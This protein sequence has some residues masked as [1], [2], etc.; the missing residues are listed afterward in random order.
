MSGGAADLAVAGLGTGAIA[1]LSGLGLIATYRLTGVL[2]V[3][4]GAIGMLGAY[5]VRDLVRDAHL[6]EYAAGFIVVCCFAPLLGLALE[7][8]VFGPL[9]AARADAGRLL[10]AG[11][12]VAVLLV[13]IATAV[14]GGA[15][16]TDAPSLLPGGTLV[17]GGVSVAAAL[18]IEL[19]LVLLVALGLAWFSRGGPTIRAVIDDRQLAE[20]AGLPARRL[21]RIGW[22]VGTMLATLTGVL[23]APQLRF[24]PSTLT[25]VL[26]ETLGVAIAAGLRSAPLAIVFAFGTAIAQAEL[27]G[28]HLTG[29]AGSV[30]EAVRS[31]LFVV[32]LLLAT[33]FTPAFSELPTSQPPASRSRYLSAYILVLVFAVFAWNLRT[34]DLHAALTIPALALVLLSFR[35]L[36]SAGMLS[37]GQAGLAGIGALAAGWASGWGILGAP[38]AGAAVAIVFAL[39]VLRQAGLHLAIATLAAATALSSFLFDQPLFTPSSVARPAFAQSD[40]GYLYFELCIVVIALAVLTALVRGQGALRLSAIRDSEIAA[41]TVGIAVDRERL[42]VFAGAGALAALGGALWAAGDQVFDPTAFAPTQG[43]IWF[44][45]AAAVGFANPT[46]LFAAAI[47]LVVADNYVAGASAIIVGVATIVLPWLRPETRWGAVMRRALDP[48]PQL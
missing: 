36:H 46:A 48:R 14:W 4:F 6:P 13:G 22:V 3:A 38:L 17:I 20:S 15:A 45:A 8:A 18:P 1:A 11:F 7:A 27:T 10:T 23:L 2:N 42:A 37:L 44:A 30:L 29:A 32:L 21:A 34:A 26:F 43:L 12:G 35:V 24:D 19:A 41:G 28:V 33:W 16:R 5:L 25:L 9:Q 40:R 31:N 47:V 39:P